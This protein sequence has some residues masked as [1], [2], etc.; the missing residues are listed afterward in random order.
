MGAGIDVDDDLHFLAKC[1]NDQQVGM[2]ILS[3]SMGGVDIFGFGT[4]RFL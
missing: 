3:C 2:V 1:D 4:G